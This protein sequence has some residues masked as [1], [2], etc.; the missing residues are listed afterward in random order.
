MVV[1]ALVCYDLDCVYHGFVYNFVVGLGDD[2][3]ESLLVAVY[4]DGL[5]VLKRTKMS[6]YAALLSYHG[7]DGDFL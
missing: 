1:I 3:L 7:C 4:D 6:V 5:C 2:Y